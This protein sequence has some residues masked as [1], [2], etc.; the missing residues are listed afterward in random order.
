M[1][2]LQVSVVR[3]LIL[4]RDPG[5]AHLSAASGLVRIG[6]CLY[7]VA[8][9]ENS[10]GVF[11]L[12][13]DKPGK[14][15]R[16]FGGDLPTSHQ[17]RK[18]AKPDL[19]ALTALRAFPGYPFGALLAVGSG[20]RSTRQRAA[21][22]TLDAQGEIVGA[23]HEVD[24]APLSEPLR[25]LFPEL[26]IEGTFVTGDRL[27][28]LQRG[29]KATPINACVAYHWD[30]FERW[31][32]AKG[33]VP[34]I[35]SIT[36]FDLGAI[37]GVPLCFTDGCAAPDGAW[38]FCAA[39]ED[40]SDSYADGQCM[41]SAVG[42]VNAAGTILALEPLALACKVEGIDASVNGDRLDVLMVTDAD[43][44]QTPALLLSATLALGSTPT[45]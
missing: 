28:L 7:V 22:M 2:V 8:D 4:A 38:V 41:G 37:D 3:Q 5:A 44:R 40:T 24:L 31:L 18:A 15:F 14:L 34:A 33:P 26:N 9:D 1:R 36:R 42:V 16:I 35:S 6:N 43:D 11:D 19:E 23:A 32:T 10:L 25:E 45:E 29:N 12:S 27:C 30:D 21:L 17:A 20:S 13:N 39:A